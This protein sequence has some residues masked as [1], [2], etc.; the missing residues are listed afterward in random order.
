MLLRS[1]MSSR[2]RLLLTMPAFSTYR[3]RVVLDLGEEL[4]EVWWERRHHSPRALKVVFLLSS[5]PRAQEKVFTLFRFA[6]KNT[7]FFFQRLLFP[8][9]SLGRRITMPQYIPR[10]DDEDGPVPR[11]MVRTSR[12]IRERE[13]ARRQSGGGAR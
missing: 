10:E 9:F 12:V 11:E 6:G 5:F 7:T 3:A 4:R 2:F 13:R 8:S 1:L